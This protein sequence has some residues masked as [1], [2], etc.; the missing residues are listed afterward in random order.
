MKKITA[1]LLAVILACSVFTFCASAEDGQVQWS[2]YA[3]ATEYGDPDNPPM[4]P[5]YRY[6]DLGIQLYINENISAYKKTG[7][8]T[9]QTTEP[10]DYTKGITMT[11]LVDAFE[12]S[13]SA[14][15]WIC[16]TLWSQQGFAQGTNEDGYGW[17]C[18]IRPTAT[19][20]AIQSYMCTEKDARADLVQYQANVNIYNHEALTFE[21]KQENDGKYHVFVCDV[22]MGLAATTFV[23]Y[24]TDNKAYVGVTGYE[25]TMHDIQLTVTEY[26]GVKPAGITGVEPYSPDGNAVPATKENTPPVDPGAPCWLYTATGT[27]KVTMGSGMAHEA[28]DSGDLRITFGETSPQIYASIGIDRF[29]DAAEFPVFAVMFTKLDD[30]GDIGS[31][32]YCA[33]DVLAP[34]ENAR[35]EFYWSDGDY[36]KNSDDGWRLLTIDLSEGDTWKE[37]ARINGFRLD[38]A[39]DSL[40]S[41][42]NCEIRWIGFFRSEAEA[43]A[44]AGMTDTREDTQP[45][46]APTEAP[47][48]KSTEAATEIAA[49][50][51]EK[52]TENRQTEEK[53]NEKT[54]GGN[55]S[56]NAILFIIIAIVA[57]LTAAGVIIALKMKKKK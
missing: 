4:V 22:D 30:I 10:Q 19:N 21:V 41:D 44:Y 56:N 37:G 28:T 12:D 9:L 23:D 17:R 43:Y 32:Y 33:G 5:G 55:K 29:Y 26:N 36:D 39:Y 31:L 11:V 52:T 14:D 18:Y 27:E 8:G 7:Y 53:Q 54:D 25:S 40:L 48:E 57:V 15:K 34:Q 49:E 3:K 42:Q 16:F 2:V 13:P 51:T 38:L 50:N 1:L 35:T 47:T 24:M 45:T 6:T 46:E 20:I